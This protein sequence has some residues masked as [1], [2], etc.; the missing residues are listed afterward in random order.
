MG[1]RTVRLFSSLSTFILLLYS[2]DVSSAQEDRQTVQ[3]IMDVMKNDGS[4]CKEGLFLYESTITKSCTEINYPKDNIKLEYNNIDTFLCLGVYDAWYKVC[5]YSSQLQRPISAATFEAD[6]KKFSPGNNITERTKFCESIKDI[7]PTYNV[8][9]PLLSSLTTTL[10]NPQ[11]CFFTCFGFIGQ[12]FNR[13]CAILAWSKSLVEEARKAT[14]IQTTATQTAT[15]DKTEINDT[16]QKKSQ[17]ISESG[18][19]MKTV[20]TENGNNNIVSDSKVKLPS[21]AIKEQEENVRQPVSQVKHKTLVNTADVKPETPADTQAN[22]KPQE[23]PKTIDPSNPK[24]VN[25][26]NDPNLSIEH[27]PDKFLNN[28]EDQQSI[29]NPEDDNQIKASNEKVKTSTISENTQD[30]DNL[31]NQEEYSPMD[32]E[33]LPF[34]ADDGRDQLESVDQNPNMPEPSEQR[35]IILHYPSMRS[36]EES[37]FFT[38]FTIISLVCIAAYMGYHNK[39]KILAMVLEGRRARNNR[40]RRRPST[41]SYRRLDCT[42]EEAVTSQCNANVTHVI[43]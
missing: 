1:K 28:T 20:T 15:A 23:K 41:A 4:L 14:K 7:T 10:Q 37:H 25:V 5:N 40:T 24:G 12:K 16:E 21:D 9:K 33:R 32:D 36:E 29:V 17:Q 26:P 43:Y 18:Q 34:D 3:N 22:N 27:S 31:A 38:Y 35:D 2:V 19:A 30:H 8:T 39:Q 11:N 42:L 6:I 13:L